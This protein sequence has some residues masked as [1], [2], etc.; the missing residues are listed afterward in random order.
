MTTKW[1]SRA[2]KI[3]SR[4][5]LMPPETLHGFEWT[6]RELRIGL[7]SDNIEELSFV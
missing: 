5:L 4:E 1:R 3:D 2:E 6:P 7:A